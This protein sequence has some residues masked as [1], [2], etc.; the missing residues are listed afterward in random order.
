MLKRFYLF[1]LILFI[2]ISAFAKEETIFLWP[3]GTPT[4]PITHTKDEYVINRDADQ[5]KFGLNRAN[6]NVSKPTMTIFPA[7]NNNNSGIGIVIFPGGAYTHI[8]IDKEGY[9]IARILNKNG[10]SAFVVNYSTKPENYKELT[11]EQEAQ[12]MQT[13]V[14]DAKRAVRIVR[15]RADEWGVNLSKVG[16][17]GFSAGGNLTYRVATNYDSGSEGDDPVAAQ[18]CKVNFAAPIYPAIWD[19]GKMVNADTPPMFVAIAN[20]DMTTPADGSLAMISALRKNGIPAELHIFTK[21][22]HGFGKGVKG[23]AVTIWPQLFIE[24]LK[25]MNILEN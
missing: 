19:G 20:D 1:F 6:Y 17:M 15:Q 7:P 14:A 25:E 22:G 23:G 18:N 21:G 2:A 11:E 16:A 3:N 24:W 13:I 10:I 8:T 12:I 5:N 9:D 4:N